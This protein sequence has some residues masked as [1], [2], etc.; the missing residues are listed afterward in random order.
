MPKIVKELSAIEVKRLLK[1][2]MHAVGNPAGLLLQIHNPVSAQ[3]IPSRSWI[4]RVR[5]A[6]ERQHIGLG[7]YPTVSLAEAREKAKKIVGDI[8]LGINPKATKKA[9]RSAL[10]QSIGASKSFRDCAEAYMKAHRAEYTNEKHRLQWASTLEAYA[11]PIIGSMLVSDI[12]MRDVLNT[13]NQSVFD[14]KTGKNL[15]TLWEKKNPTASRLQGRMKSVL[16][17]AIVNEYRSSINPALW[18]GYLATQLSAPSKIRSVAHHPS[19]PYEKIGDFMAKL[20]KNDCTS[21]RALEFLIMTGVRSGSVREAEWSE[22]DFDNEIWI[23]PAK[24]TKTKQEHRV[25]LPKQAIKL[26]KSLPKLASSKKIFPSPKGKALSDMALSELMR[27]MRKRNEITVDA[28]PHGFRSTFRVWSAERTNFPD[29][30]RKLA[31]GHAVSDD[32]LKAYQRTDL[33][34]K[35]RKLMSEWANFL[36][37]ASIKKSTQVTPMRRKA[38]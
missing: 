9:A 34:E 16:D 36:D 31:S 14:E 15:G 1:A 22:I 25:P 21:A 12:G 35:R 24:N 32:I 37:Q 30:I 19:L 28:V 20:R 27:G 4:L 13:L 33:L 18:S 26:L 10:A 11:Y 8:K 29:E 17:F 38:A 23:I 2:G 7:S 6:G 5:V 3:S